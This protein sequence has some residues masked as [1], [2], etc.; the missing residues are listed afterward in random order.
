MRILKVTK[1][2]KNAKMRLAS[3]QL[4]KHI[5]ISEFWNPNNFTG[6]YFI[7]LNKTFFQKFPFSLSDGDVYF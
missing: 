4:P 1:H 2:W 6:I 7:T 5:R 3:P